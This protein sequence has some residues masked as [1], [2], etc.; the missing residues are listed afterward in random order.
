MLDI[1]DGQQPQTGKNIN[2]GTKKL[3]MVDSASPKDENWPY[4]YY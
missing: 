4:A 2:Q 3:A 1:F